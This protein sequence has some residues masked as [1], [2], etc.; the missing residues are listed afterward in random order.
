MKASFPEMIKNARTKAGLTTRQ[1][2]DELATQGVRASTAFINQVENS[3]TKPT[4]DFAYAT[5]EAVGLSVEDPLRAAF[6]YRVQWCIDRERKAL[7]DLAKKE[8]L[9]EEAVKRITSLRGLK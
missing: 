3:T 1:L 6:L 2:A 4:F 7:R 8:G 9:G 5:A